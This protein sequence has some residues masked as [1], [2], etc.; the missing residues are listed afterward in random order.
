MVSGSTYGTPRGTDERVS[1]ISIGTSSAYERFS[2]DG[3][4]MRV[5]FIR[6]SRVPSV[7]VVKTNFD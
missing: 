3:L 1:G 7:R 5:Q 2:E 6:D 4:N